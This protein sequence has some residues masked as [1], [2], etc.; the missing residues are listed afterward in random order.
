MSGA[1]RTVVRK[2][3][4]DGSYGRWPAYETGADQHGHWLFSPAGTVYW[5]HSPPRPALEWE[6]GRGSE[7]SEGVSELWLVAAD[8]WW[9]AKWVEVG[10]V[11]QVHVDICRPPRNLNGEWVFTD[12]ELDPY[13]YSD[14][15]VGVGDEAEFAEACNS[16]QITESDAIEARLTADEV[17]EWL[18]NATE[19]FGATGWKRFRTAHA[20]DLA[21]LWIEALVPAGRSG[22][23]APTA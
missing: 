23:A 22:D 4:L 7:M 18:R 6:V 1:P 12:L 13:W 15:R 17:L 11:R 5:G 16:G 9:V 19:P 10:G 14:G 21:P 3:K 8:R 20:A 2:S